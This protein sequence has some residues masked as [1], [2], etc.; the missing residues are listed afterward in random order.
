MAMTIPAIKGRMGTNDYYEAK[1]RAQELV[2]AARVASERD[3]WASL[4]IEERLQR[5]KPGL[6]G[7]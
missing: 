4:S 1:M 5:I 2:Q 3:T 6:A 7:G